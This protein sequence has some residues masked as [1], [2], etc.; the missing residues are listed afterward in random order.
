MF[1]TLETGLP[2]S[3]DWLS[4][5]AYIH[6]YGIGNTCNISKN[7]ATKLNLDRQWVWRCA[8]HSIEIVN[9]FEKVERMWIL[10]KKEEFEKRNFSLYFLKNCSQAS[11]EFF[12]FTLSLWIYLARHTKWYIDLC[13][14]RIKYIFVMLWWTL[15][16]VAVC[17]IN[18]SCELHSMSICQFRKRKYAFCWKS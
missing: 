13:F 17:Y 12:L 5:K 3:I 4:I 11:K 10:Q 16:T 15:H 2:F 14:C 7:V 18:K 6:V 1:S 8:E 9:F